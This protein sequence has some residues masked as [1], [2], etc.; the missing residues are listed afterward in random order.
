MIIYH[1][2]DTL[3]NDLSWPCNLRPM[4]MLSALEET[5][6]EVFALV[7]TC[8]ERKKKFKLLEGKLRNCDE[9]I[10]YYCE[11]SNR[12]T[13]LDWA[14][15]N[16]LNFEFD[17]KV[18]GLLKAQGV[19]TSLFY[20]DLHWLLPKVVTSR[21]GD[22]LRTQIKAAFEKRALRHW[23]KSL[24][25]L[26]LPHTT[27][28]EHIPFDFPNSEI[29]SL[30]PGGDGEPSQSFREEG[31][32]LNLIYVGSIKPK[33]Y[34]LRGFLTEFKT[35][36]NAH[37]TLITR[38]DGL[39][40]VGDLYRFEAMKNVTVC[41]AQ[42]DGLAEYYQA[43]DIAVLIMSKSDYIGFSMPVKVFEAISY[44]LPLIVTA[45]QLAV[46]DFVKKEKVGWVVKDPLEFNKLLDYLRDHP[47][48]VERFR[49][50]VLEV[51]ERHSWLARA[52]EVIKLL[53]KKE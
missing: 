49:Q 44:G 32:P 9:E 26:F 11:S 23:Q 30:P 45:E 4:K 42:G 12:F 15:V 20:R 27:M 34:D 41:H 48:E 53:Q 37:L 47:A 13:A 8:N 31:G 38:P 24:D 52:Q 5:G 14:K 50:R 35:N 36:Q 43:A 40:L 51:R 16:P 17:A 22:F 33:V 19:K 46:A 3:G 1:H 2:P 28:A 6:E 10:L 18:A 7:G 25:I 29:R 39:A 21:T